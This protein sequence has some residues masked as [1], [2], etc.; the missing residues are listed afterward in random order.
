MSERM[1]N[2][3]EIVY[4]EGDFGT[5][6]YRVEAGSVRIVANAGQPGETVLTVMA[7]GQYFG[8]LSALGGY[9]RSAT[10][11][12]AE[13]GTRLLE[14]GD[15]DMDATFRD[16]P[17]E[18]LDL[19]RY[20]GGRIRELSA[21]YEEAS[22][23]LA[24]MKGAGTPARSESFMDKV[25][26]FASLGRSKRAREKA[27]VEREYALEGETV[28]PVAAYPAGTILYREGEPGLCMYC[29]HWGSVGIYA[30]YGTD[31]QKKLT[32]VAVNRFF[33]EMGLLSGDPRSATAVILENNTTL[34]AIYPEDMEELLRKN[35][36][37]VW[38]VLEYT[39]LRLQ[40]LTDDYEAV[41]REI[42]EASAT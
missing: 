31:A 13:D 25:R 32:E 8:E 30:G 40:R 20:L 27:S 4:R 34:E 17:E 14:L 23:A 42:C 36:A 18:V 41:C 12:A 39:G 38:M 29:V 16:R 26:R 28:R 3:D 24:E 21:D 1:F 2:R 15:A 37:R 22:K 33:G 11:V 5:L 9:A 10:A 19:L 6:Y 35:P 7:P